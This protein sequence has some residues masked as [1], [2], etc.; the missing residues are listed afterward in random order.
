MLHSVALALLCVGA[1]F[2]GQHCKR[3]VAG[4]WTRLARQIAGVTAQRFRLAFVASASA[5]VAKPHHAG[6]TRPGVELYA[7]GAVHGGF[8]RG[9]RE[10]ARA[11]RPPPAI[12]KAI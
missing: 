7:T 12:I 5:G 9:A 2:P 3:A 11:V 4:Y 8:D 6:D 10:S 1:L